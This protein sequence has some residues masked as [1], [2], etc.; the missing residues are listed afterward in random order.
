MISAKKL[1]K[2]ARKWQKIAARS[3]RRISLPRNNKDIVDDENCTS[4]F[5][6]KKGHFVVYTTDEKRFVMPLAYLKHNILRELFKMSEEEFGVSSDGPIRLPCDAVFMEYVVTLIKRGVAKDFEKAL[7]RSMET[8][9]CSSSASSFH[10]GLTL[11]QQTLV[12]GY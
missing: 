1:I 9:R 11:S 3:R 5:V 2:M 7:I 10:Q 12:S 6:V 4:S 8:G